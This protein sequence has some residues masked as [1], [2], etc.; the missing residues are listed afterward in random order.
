[1]FLLAKAEVKIVMSEFFQNINMQLHSKF[2]KR[3]LEAIKGWWKRS[4]V[5]SWFER[6]QGSRRSM[7]RETAARITNK[8]VIR[9]QV[10]KLA[11]SFSTN[12]NRN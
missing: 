4:E 7:G 9:A 5:A 8:D 6:I 3:T 12:E 10:M 2:P 1:M 11:S